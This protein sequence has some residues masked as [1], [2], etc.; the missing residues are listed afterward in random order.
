MY[1]S[2]NFNSNQSQQIFMR[3][4]DVTIS[5]DSKPPARATCVFVHVACVSFPAFVLLRA[6]SVGAVVGLV[7][8]I[9]TWG[10]FNGRD[11]A[12]VAGVEITIADT[13]R[14][15][16]W[17]NMAGASTCSDCFSL[18][19]PRLEAR[20]VTLEPLDLGVVQPEGIWPWFPDQG[21]RA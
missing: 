8:T 1:T 16:R 9:W 17:H 15:S 5:A 18:V 19:R 14:W 21:G 3:H 6:S 13:I 10:W 2:S 4:A 20:L 12:V 7:G 11:P